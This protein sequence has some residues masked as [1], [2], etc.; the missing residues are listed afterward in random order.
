MKKENNDMYND[1]MVSLIKL[2]TFYV[3]R[4]HEALKNNDSKMYRY[5]Q[6]KIEK[7]EVLMEKVRNKMM[8]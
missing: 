8:K 7:M 6:H 1:M 5:Y 2:R 4:Q 3:D